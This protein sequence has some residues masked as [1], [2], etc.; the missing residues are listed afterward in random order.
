MPIHCRLPTPP[1]PV[2]RIMLLDGTVLRVSGEQAARR[3]SRKRGIPEPPV[4]LWG[5]GPDE[6][7][8]HCR[9]LLGEPTEG[10]G[11]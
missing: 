11:R 9:K 2:W 7:C 8:P 6:P 1:W 5:L 4:S 10:G 3:E